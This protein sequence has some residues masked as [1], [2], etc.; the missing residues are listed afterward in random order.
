MPTDAVCPLCRKPSRP[1]CYRCGGTGWYWG[2]DPA[3]RANADLPCDQC[4]RCRP[5]P[6]CG[7]GRVAV[8]A[9]AECDGVG[10]IERR[11]GG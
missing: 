2:Y 8:T 7:D 10:I 1:G 9:C 4:C 11:D 6:C 3:R 5:C